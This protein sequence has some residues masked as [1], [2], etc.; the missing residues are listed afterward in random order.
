MIGIGDKKQAKGKRVV[1]KVND[2]YVFTDSMSEKLIAL[3]VA[4]M[5]DKEIRIGAIQIDDATGYV[6]RL[7]GST[8]NVEEI[9][10]P[11]GVDF[12]VFVE[13][14][15]GEEAIERIEPNFPE[16]EEKYKVSSKTKIY[17]YSVLTLLACA[18]VVIGYGK[19]KTEHEK[20]ETKPKQTVIL[21]LTPSE[22]KEEAGAVSYQMLKRIV[23]RINDLREGERIRAI[24]GMILSM[25]EKIDPNTLKET[26]VGNLEFT[27]E[28]VYPVKGSLKS[29]EFFIRREKEQ[30][31]KTRVA[32]GSAPLNACGMELL[33]KGFDLYNP[34]T[35][36][37]KG[38]TK[39]WEDTKDLLEKLQNCNI[40]IKSIA[41][42]D[43]R[44]KLEVVLYD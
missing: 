28:T 43:G 6:I 14:L 37:F 17:L 34:D 16:W 36:T 21:T 40:E 18:V 23:G 24:Q 15:E 22:R 33:K 41:I 12:S 32:S 38:T 29:G 3:T 9:E 39:S 31:K 26:L 25:K 11:K 20:K 7:E 44:M 35:N 27:Y 4:Y 8:V 5:L 19:Y 1:F 13:S 30:I 42:V 10:I 2:R